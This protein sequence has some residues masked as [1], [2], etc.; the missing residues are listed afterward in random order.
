[1][2]TYLVSKVFLQTLSSQKYL[3]IRELA[4]NG[5]SRHDEIS[6]K[7][8][9]S[10]QSRENQGK[11]ISA[12]GFDHDDKINKMFD[13]IQVS[14]NSDEEELDYEDDILENKVDDEMDTFQDELEIE[15]NEDE[16][17]VLAKQQ[18]KDKQVDK[19][20][21]SEITDKASDGNEMVLGVSSASLTEE[22]LM[23]NNPHLKKLLNRMLDERIK[24]A[25]NKGE[26]SSSCILSGMA[27][28][29]EGSQVN[30]KVNKKKQ[31]AGI[32]KSPSDTTIYVP[33]LQKARVKN[34]NLTALPFD[35]VPMVNR[36]QKMQCNTNYP[37][38]TEMI[39]KI[40]N[41]V[42]QICLDQQQEEQHE[43]Q[44][45]QSS[46]QIRSSV[47]VPGYEEVQH[48]M[49]PALVE[50][51]KFKA[52]VEKPPGMNFNFQKDSH[53][54][55][56]GDEQLTQQP[57]QLLMPTSQ[58]LLVNQVNQR[59]CI[60]NGLSDDNFFHM[61][62]HVDVNL[63]KKIENGEYVDLDNLLPKDNLFSTRAMT[64]ET[65]LEWVQ[66]EGGTYLVSAKSTSRINC[67]RCWEQAFRI[68]ATLYCTKHPNRA[69]EILQYVSVINT[70]SMSFSWENV[71]NYDMMFK[72][73]MEFYP[74]RSWAVTYNQ[75]WNLP[76]TNPI[77]HSGPGQYQRRF[78]AGNGGNTM[79]VGK[80][81]LDYCWSFNKGVKCK[82]GKKCKFI[83]RCSYCDAASHGVINC[84]K[85]DK[86]E[87]MSNNRSH[88]NSAS[89]GRSKNKS[90]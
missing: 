57:E 65:K 55:I 26:S 73:L 17:V 2:K 68:Y 54:N 79:T 83:E 42:D 86:R 36:Q 74:K 37:A 72:Q 56:I 14:V 51:E 24:E 88:Q 89:G 63:K 28:Q 53:D 46:L 87:G 75:M 4:T 10:F 62:C 31:N 33:A 61:T 90:R 81:K 3:K 85:L 41:F 18:V 82:F 70:A 22:E 52:T 69:R 1:M 44:I 59:Q 50:A 7:N 32:V 60:G 77:S 49:E 8:P 21:N 34:S 48:R 35:N 23:M 16:R 27:P 43:M 78:S 12:K 19:T 40:S 11:K 38:N 76:M 80:K 39:A 47:N 30:Q 58:Q 15:R 9:K 6:R 20:R 64:N 25:Q 5:R 66:S 84:D 67:F 29:V 71:Y 45:A 13:G